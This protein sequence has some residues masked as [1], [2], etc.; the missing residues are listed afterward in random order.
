MNMTQIRAITHFWRE[1]GPARWFAKDAAF[2]AAI[3]EG[4]EPLHHEAARGALSSWLD[5]AEGALALLLLT[6][7]FPRNL[8]RGSAHAFATDPLARAV[9]AEALAL[10][11]DRMTEPALRPFFYL[12]FEHSEDP[13]DQARAVHL[14]THHRDETG[15]EESLRYA[16]LHE[17]LIRRFGRF[18]HR[19]LAFGRVTTPEEQAYLDGG[20]FAG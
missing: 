8:Y 9:A 16:L 1:A 17:E 10:G 5:E 11:H 13:H 14:F 3:R 15:D 6:D 2:D 4:F 18:P 12:P 20:G 7:Q 19:N